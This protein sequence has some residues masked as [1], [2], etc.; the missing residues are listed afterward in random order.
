MTTMKPLV[1]RL[2]SFFLRW[3]EEQSQQFEKIFGQEMKSVLEAV[4]DNSAVSNKLLE[5]LVNNAHENERIDQPK[6]HFLKNAPLRREMLPLITVKVEHTRPR[7][8]DLEKIYGE[9]STSLT[10]FDRRTKMTPIDSTL[11]KGSKFPMFIHP[12]P[13]FIERFEY[14]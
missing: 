3:L 6:Q 9:P 2:K 14:P 11:K 13:T 7:M 5:I 8:I 10:E 1:H 4:C 12:Y